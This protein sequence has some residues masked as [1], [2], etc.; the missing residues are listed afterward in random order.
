MFYKL[1]VI[2]YF[3]LLWDAMMTVPQQSKAQG[4]FPTI[5]HDDLIAAVFW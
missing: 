3:I 1:T 5:S 2:L 4:K